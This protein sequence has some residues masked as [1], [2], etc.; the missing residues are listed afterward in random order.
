MKQQY[1][2]INAVSKVGDA[3]AWCGIWE[4]QFQ[5]FEL[6]RKHC[7]GLENETIDDITDSDNNKR[8]R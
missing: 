7:V 3:A 5:Q 2:L 1:L 6:Y 4:E 8:Y